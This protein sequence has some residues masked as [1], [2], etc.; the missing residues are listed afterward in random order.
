MATGSFRSPTACSSGG[1]NSCL[2]ESSDSASVQITYQHK[3]RDVSLHK[4]GVDPKHHDRVMLIRNR[5]SRIY[6]LRRF[7]DY[8]LKL[9]LRTVANLGLI[10]TILAGISYIK[11]AAFPVRPEATLEHFLINRFGRKLYTL[12][13]RSYTQKVWGVP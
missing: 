2:F 13:F 1:P 5:C 12:F 8:P 10:R 9:N 7:F 4:N 11:S 6:F 3:A